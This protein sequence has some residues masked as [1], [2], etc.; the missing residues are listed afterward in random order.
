LTSGRPDGAGPPLRA[1]GGVAVRFDADGV[2]RIALVHRP[3]FDDWSLPKGKVKR[4]EHTV[5]AAVREVREE[6]GVDAV[7][8]ARLPT[9]QYDVWAG[10]GLVEKVVDYFAMRVTTEHEFRPDD[11]VDELAWLPLAEAAARAT[12]PHDKKVLR[13]YGELPSLTRPV[14]LLRHVSAGDPDQWSGPDTERPL[15]EDGRAMADRLATV[16]TCFDPTILVS[17]EPLR[18]RQTLAPLAATLDIAVRIDPRF[19]EDSAPVAAVAG[20]RELVAENA[21]AVVCSQ[22]KLIPRVVAELDA[23]D[24]ALYRTAKGDGWALSFTDRPTGGRASTVIADRF[25]PSDVRPA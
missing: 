9:V 3:R 17:A 5:C 4:G 11:E 6:T 22:G 1:A 13:A 7:V 16:L 2:A 21:M 10:T 23:R 25:T 24:A 20:L 14:L 8:G 18:C 15:D 12:Y 19:N